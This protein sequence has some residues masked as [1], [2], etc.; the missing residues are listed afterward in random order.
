L[1]TTVL[2]LVL[3]GFYVVGPQDEA[4]LERLGRRVAPNRGPG[5]HYKLPW[6]VDKVR[7]LPTRRVQTIE[8]GFRSGSVR[9]DGEP[10]SYEWNVQ[11]RTGRFQRKSEESLFLTGDQNMIE[12][13]ATVHYRLRRPENYLYR[14]SDP[15]TTLRA[16]AES[17]LHAATTGQPIDALLTTGRGAFE[18]S[19]RTELQHML[20]RY[21]AGVDV[22]QVRLLDVHPSIE[23]VSAFRDVAGAS[24]EKSRVVNEAEGYRN[25][26]VALARGN[27]EALLQSAQAHSAGRKNRSQGDASRFVQTEQGFRAAAGPNETR[28]YLETLEQVLPGKRKLIIDSSKGRRHLLLLEDGVVVPP[29][30]LVAPVQED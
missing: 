20:D 28:L 4:I 8:V 27:A 2:L 12:I 3:S 1:Y 5:L 17:A 16:A 21:E 19:A 7:V 10:A 14:H 25:E 13:N 9:Q 6:P 18:Q 24:E 23:V 30:A 15:E 26:R 22:L 11:H 29:S